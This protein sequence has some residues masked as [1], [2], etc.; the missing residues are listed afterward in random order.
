MRSFD[1]QGIRLFDNNA[2]KLPRETSGH[3]RARVQ[4][5]AAAVNANVG[6]WRLAPVATEIEAQAV[7]WIA[8][9]IGYP[10]DG[11]GLF[12]S[13]GNMANMV[14]FLAART[15]QASPEVR[16]HGLSAAA[17]RP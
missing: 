3:D 6:A 15:A 12:V 2:L 10:E 7:R 11:G 17:P 14:G 5:L 1:K 13:G 9:L 8:E 4:M 16:A